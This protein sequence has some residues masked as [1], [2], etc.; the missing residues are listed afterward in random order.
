MPPKKNKQ[1]PLRPKYIVQEVEFAGKPSLV[2]CRSREA[3]P[4]PLLALCN[5]LLL[6]NPRATVIDTAKGNDGTRTV[7]LNKLEDYVL[8]LLS[9]ELDDDIKAGTKVVADRAQVMKDYRAELD[10]LQ[11]QRMVCPRHSETGDFNTICAAEKSVFR[12]LNVLR[13]HALL[14]GPEDN[15]LCSLTAQDKSYLELYMEYESYEKGL[16]SEVPYDESMHD[17][18][19]VIKRV[20][21]DGA[22]FTKYGLDRLCQ[23]TSDNELF[24]FYLNRDF[25]V[26]Y[27]KDGE[28]YLLATDEEMLSKYPDL[29]WIGL[30]E[31]FNH[32]NESC[33]GAEGKASEVQ[34]GAD[35]KLIEITVPRRFLRFMNRCI[36][37][38]KEFASSC[39]MYKFY[40]YKSRQ[41][42][43]TSHIGRL[44][45]KS[46]LVFI[47]NVHKSGYSWN[48]KF[49]EDDMFVEF[50]IVDDLCIGAT[51]FFI[52]LPA[53]EGF[54]KDKGKE[55][56]R[57]FVKF[58]FPHYCPAED[59]QLP[60]YF[61]RFEG[62]IEEMP[63]LED[64]PLE[65][66]IFRLYMTNHFFSKA[67]LVRL[68]L[69]SNV[70]RLCDSEIVHVDQ[71]KAKPR[72]GLLDVEMTA[73]KTDIGDWLDQLSHPLNKVYA[74]SRIETHYN[75]PNNN[76]WTCWD[77]IELGRHSEQHGMD[78]T[79]ENGVQEMQHPEVIDLMLEQDLRGL[80][81]DAIKILILMYN[82]RCS[83]SLGLPHS[84]FDNQSISAVL[85]TR[86]DGEVSLS[87]GWCYVSCGGHL[88]SGWI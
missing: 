22:E 81:A 60:C 5:L 73:F 11:N 69:V 61:D 80:I 78:H 68:T 53:F 29:M 38:F 33:E 12:A 30:D 45:A 15:D 34:Q 76:K 14:P 86:G 19:L 18:M 8:A 26:V 21:I 51:N 56:L 49:T 48:G 25:H 31:K 35:V 71:T 44:C 32:K 28:L 72:F 1:K 42:C 39:T 54:D 50:E 57:T 79:M 70:Y 63:G 77:A 46:Y 83:L 4:C 64:P 37:T 82:L 88:Q 55:D 43:S 66:E 41:F 85:N 13:R 3:A 16:A 47:F 7:S 59:S 6:K 87:S 40:W 9:A 24:I 84:R 27:K 2:V 74:G 36:V 75:Q 52:T 65:L 67:P 17:R 10:G 58:L 23:D 62:D 20:L